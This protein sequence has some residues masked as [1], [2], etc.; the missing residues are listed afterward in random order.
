[1]SR[2]SEHHIRHS[3]NDL[4]S[5]RAMKNDMYLPYWALIALAI[6]IIYFAVHIFRLND[7][8]AVSSYQVISG[9]NS[10]TN[11]YSAVILRDETI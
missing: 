1:M 6:C 4:R 5:R 11:I 9:S 2:S 8:R 10:T 7:H 3:K